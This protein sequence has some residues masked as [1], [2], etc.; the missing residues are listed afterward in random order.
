M[1]KID[2]LFFDPENWIDFKGEKGKRELELLRNLDVQYDENGLGDEHEDELMSLDETADA[3]TT[4]DMD[5]QE[6]WVKA[7]QWTR[8]YASKNYDKFL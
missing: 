6:A 3:V 2:E 4:W 5:P 7:V 1:D 8:K